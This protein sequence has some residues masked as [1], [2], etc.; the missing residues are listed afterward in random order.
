MQIY[1]SLKAP[2]IM[3]TIFSGVRHLPSCPKKQF[4]ARAGPQCVG[5]AIL[6]IF[7]S[8]RDVGNL[9][10]IT[11]LALDT[12]HRT[13]QSWHLD[14]SSQVVSTS[15]RAQAT[16]KTQLTIT[17][18]HMFLSIT[19]NFFQKS[20]QFRELYLSPTS[21][22]F[23]WLFFLGLM[24]RMWFAQKIFIGITSLTNKHKF[25]LVYLS[26]NHGIAE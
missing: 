3:S 17:F 23:W 15:N 7:Y 18:H 1:E 13:E 12:S 24:T 4:I 10:A 14:T 21:F 20:F 5:Q 6:V 16:M 9:V 19:F 26:P 25:A 22:R 11:L 8:G 2:S